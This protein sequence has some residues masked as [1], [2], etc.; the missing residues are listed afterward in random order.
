MALDK[1]IASGKEHRKP[2]GKGYGNY[3]KSV[4]ATCRNHGGCPHCE[5]N[6]TYKNRKKLISMMDAIR[7]EENKQKSLN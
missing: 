6:R 1:A 5:G 3:P 2:Y 4:D 7:E